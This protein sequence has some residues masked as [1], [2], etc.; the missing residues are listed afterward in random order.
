MDL[1]HNFLKYQLPGA[2]K[3]EV[4]SKSLITYLANDKIFVIGL[5]KFDGII[6]EQVKKNI[7]N[8]LEKTAKKIYFFSLLDNSEMFQM[9]SDKIA[10]GSY[11][12][13]AT[14]PEHTIH[15]DNQPKL[16]ARNS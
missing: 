13:I 14:Q 4:I 11:A 5:G 7:F 15:F 3:G 10:W 1:L 16:K 8:R 12:W 6:T 9:F 2:Q